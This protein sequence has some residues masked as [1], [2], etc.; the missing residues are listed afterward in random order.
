DETRLRLR[1]ERVDGIRGTCGRGARGR[2]EGDAAD[3]P[4]RHGRRPGPRVRLHRHRR[5]PSAFLRGGAPED[6]PGEEGPHA[7]H[8]VKRKAERGGW[9]PPDLRGRVAIVAG[10]S[11]G[12]GRGIA[13]AL[14][15][16]GAT[17]YVTGRTRRGGPKP[18]DDVPGTIDDTADE[19]TRRGGR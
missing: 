6:A 17:V 9:R 8:E 11:R 19:V 10:A 14:G 5:P 12:A 7:E 18:L 2:R 16:A 15:D 1:Q 4:A 13:L 3:R